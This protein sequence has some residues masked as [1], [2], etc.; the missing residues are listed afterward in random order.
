MGDLLWDM[1]GNSATLAIPLSATLLSAALFS[2][3]RATVQA[4]PLP[5]FT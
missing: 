2:A 3:I 1:L 5:I 4:G